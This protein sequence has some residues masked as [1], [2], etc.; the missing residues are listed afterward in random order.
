MASVQPMNNST[1]SRPTSASSASANPSH[2]SK[3]PSAWEP[4]HTPRTADSDRPPLSRRD[5][6]NLS[7]V[8]F[9]AASELSG[10]PVTHGQSRSADGSKASAQAVPTQQSASVA[11]TPRSGFANGN[12]KSGAGSVSNGT[13][14]AQCSSNLSTSR[15]NGSTVGS[16]KSA[17]SNGS[18]T[19]GNSISSANTN[20]NINNNNNNNNSSIGGGSGISNGNV[21]S[22]VGAGVAGAAKGNEEEY[23]PVRVAKARLQQILGEMERMRQDHMAAVAEIDAHYKSLEEESQKVFVEFVTHL[24]ESFRAKLEKRSIQVRELEERVMSLESQKT[25]TMTRL[26]GALD[27]AAT[28]R[29]VAR[30]SDEETEGMMT[31][32]RARLVLFM[33]EKQRLEAA[34]EAELSLVRQHA[35]SITEDDLIKLRDLKSQLWTIERKLAD[36]LDERKDVKKRILLWTTEF[37]QKNGRKPEKEDKRAIKDEYV[38]YKVLSDKCE[39]LQ[40]DM[41]NK[42]KDIAAFEEQHANA[43]KAKA[44]ERQNDLERLALLEQEKLVLQ[45]EIGSLRSQ[46]DEV[47]SRLDAATAEKADMQI[48]LDDLQGK[49]IQLVVDMENQQSQLLLAAQKT[50]AQQ[51]PLTVASAGDDEE[52]GIQE[53]SVTVEKST[54]SVNRG[55]SKSN[56]AVANPSESRDG[57]AEEQV[58][59]ATAAVATAGSSVVAQMMTDVQEQNKALREQNEKMKNDLLQSQHNSGSLEQQ[60]KSLQ[61]D[62]D[63]LRQQ[64]ATAETDWASRVSDATAER[65]TLREEVRKLQISLVKERSKATRAAQEA[66]PSE[67]SN[68]SSVSGSLDTAD[69]ASASASASAPTSSVEES[70]GT[71]L[72]ASKNATATSEEDPVEKMLQELQ[73]D[74]QRLRDESQSLSDKLCAAAKSIAE[75]EAAIAALQLSESQLLTEKTTLGGKIA[76]M[77]IVVAA[78]TLDAQKAIGDFTHAKEQYKSD[79]T[80]AKKKLKKYHEEIVKL[81]EQLAAAKA[82]QAAAVSAA[83]SAASRSEDAPTPTPAPGT[84]AA[85]PEPSAAA[86][87][88]PAPVSTV[89]SPPA[90][91]PEPVIVY[92]DRIVEK[93]VTVY[94]DRVVEKVVEKEVIVEKERVV[95][96]VVERIVENVVEK[97]KLVV[98]YKD[99]SEA[100][101][102][103]SGA[104]SMQYAITALEDQVA[105]LE[106]NNN[107]LREDRNK[108]QGELDLAKMVAE[109]FKAELNNT[110]EESR[111]AKRDVADAKTKVSEAKSKAEEYRMQLETTK[112]ELENVNAMLESTQSGLQA[113]QREIDLA[114]ARLEESRQETADVRRDLAESRSQVLSLKNELASR[115]VQYVASSSATEADQAEEQGEDVEDEDAAD[116]GQQEE[117]EEDAQKS[118]A[119]VTAGSSTAPKG[120]PGAGT[121]PASAGKAGS[122]AEDKSAGAERIKKLQEENTKLSKKVKQLELDLR[123]AKAGSGAGAG[124]AADV[125]QLETQLKTQ[126]QNFKR[127]LAETTKKYEG[128]A[129]AA[130]EKATRYETEYQK[131][132]KMIEK[133]ETDLATLQKE[134]DKL[135]KTAGGASRELAALQKALEDEQKKAAEATV[136]A[137]QVVG[138]KKEKALLEAALKDE[139]VLRKKLHNEIEDMKGKIRVYCRVRPLSKTEVERGDTPAVAYPDEFTIKVVPKN[140]EFIYDRVFPPDCSQSE[141]FED[142]QHLIQSAVDGFNVCVFA[143]GQTGSGKTFTIAGDQKNPGIVPRAMSTLYAKLNELESKGLATYT[144]SCYML[145]LYND[146]LFDLFL[147]KKQRVDPPKL[148][149]KKDTKGLVVVAGSTIRDA[150]TYEILE[151]LYYDGTSTRH[152]RATDMNATSSRSHLVFSILIEVTNKE[153]KAVSKGKLSLVDLAGSERLSKTNITDPQGVLEA[154]SINKSLTAL[155]DVIS[156]LS[157]GE[158]F[159]PYRNNKLTMLM[160]DSLGGNAKTLMFV[161]L[162]PADYNTDETLTS[163]QYAARVK[164]ITNDASK[165]NESK[166]IARLQEII[167]KLKSGERVEDAAEIA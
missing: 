118:D 162:S 52:I 110:K 121:A 58:A 42:K 19:D 61:T 106:A 89:S 17:M 125:K 87:A 164:L 85:A 111:D 137:D 88:P 26:S 136:L 60:L 56:V 3:A 62:V 38:R 124:S 143:Y 75:K 48:K 82:E 2:Q 90:P 70:S 24:K 149:I 127:E 23:I 138:L 167:K 43:G 156:A 13:A 95:E 69:S 25:E 57:D 150:P 11:S 114:V 159:I 20:R 74:Q 66:K 49:I 139:Q 1:T 28:W 71:P 94:Q 83:A 63:S 22:A 135:N 105:M 53:E 80:E 157:T 41:H 7:T 154:K 109:E 96:K 131:Q 99:A 30:E 65:D 116:R 98:V 142:T 27:D 39:S 115:P 151:K 122:A 112:V 29:T 102:D 132:K 9:A 113:A 152:T 73:G 33:Q 103:G 108:M 155:G 79:M 40:K 76:E 130:T 55:M 100:P 37:E 12:S 120:K 34:R 45:S 10:T 134:Y 91:A 18:D 146:N 128:E 16:T 126:E 93:P 67:D 47:Q 145:E 21:S 129:K 144:V 163:L 104:N 84:A 160:S 92:Q 5:T 117:D 165:N 140:R 97:E 35:S 64:K 86:A 31:V 46:K 153:T 107:Q 141:V 15:N 72:E 68:E 4:G 161:N 81:R 59:P 147:E 50:H 133:L 158:A 44:Q 8:S 77:D 166:E 54:R 123:K 148:D 51:Q 78:R 101:V 32:F 6:I 36:A 119:K 14:S